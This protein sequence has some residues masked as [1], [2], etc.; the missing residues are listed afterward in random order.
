MLLAYNFFSIHLLLS[1]YCFVKDIFLKKVTITSFSD[2]DV[3]EDIKKTKYIW[4]PNSQKLILRILYIDIYFYIFGSHY[5]I[6][7]SLLYL[8]L[9][10]PIMFLCNA[11]ILSGHSYSE[12]RKNYRKSNEIK[13]I[14]PMFIMV[15][16]NYVVNSFISTMYFVTLLFG[17]NA[18]VVF[19]YMS[20]GYIVLILPE[21]NIN[22]RLF[23]DNCIK[24]ETHLINEKWIEENASTIYNN[25][26]YYRDNTIYYCNCVLEN[27]NKLNDSLPSNYR[28]NNLK[29]YFNLQTSNVEN[30][31]GEHKYDKLSELSNTLT[32]IKEEDHGVCLANTSDT[33]NIDSESVITE[34]AP[35]ALPTAVP[36]EEVLTEE[37]LTEEVLTEEVSNESKKD[38]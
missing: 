4:L 6:I 20:I 2:F 24:T 3:I 38:I 18:Y 14:N 29:H 10:I 23:Y 30:D 26:S 34:E 7:K 11:V 15:C 25:Y 12:S 28:F 17:I 1:L 8:I 36:T 31:L 33:T 13:T 35:T 9:S 5:Y 37:V 21:L 19:L 22:A 27:V 32:P 16:D